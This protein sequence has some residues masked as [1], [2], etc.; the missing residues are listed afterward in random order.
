MFLGFL[1]FLGFLGSK[2]PKNPVP[3]VVSHPPCHLP[4]AQEGLRKSNAVRDKLEELCRQLQKDNKEVGL[5][6]HSQR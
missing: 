1:R 2:A 6:P 3:M 5:S 4:P